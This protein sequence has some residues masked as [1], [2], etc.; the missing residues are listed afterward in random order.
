MTTE[1]DRDDV[2]EQER[3]SVEEE[4]RAAGA[5]EGIEPAAPDHADDSGTTYLGVEE[6][7]VAPAERGVAPDD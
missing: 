5:P 1:R 4:R 7:S 6:P 2:A 3:A